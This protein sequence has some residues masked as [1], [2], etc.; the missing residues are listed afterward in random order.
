M[1]M[2]ASRLAGKRFP[3]RCCRRLPLGR[4]GVKFIDGIEAASR[5]A[6]TAAG[7]T[8]PVAEFRR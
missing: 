5:D 1:H 3:D 4:C 6:L 2:R 8:L 7:L